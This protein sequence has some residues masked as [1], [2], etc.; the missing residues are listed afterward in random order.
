[1]IKVYD[2]LGGEVATLVN[3]E[4]TLGKYEVKLNASD[5]SSGIYFYQLRVGSTTSSGKNFIQTKKMILMM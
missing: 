4:F 3:K 2:I 5:F 1:M